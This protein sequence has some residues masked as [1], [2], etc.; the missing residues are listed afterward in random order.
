[1]KG[2]TRTDLNSKLN[3]QFPFLK[4]NNRLKTDSFPFPWICFLL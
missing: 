4:D 1:M 3:Y 2:G